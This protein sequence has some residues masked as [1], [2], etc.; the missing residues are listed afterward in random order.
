MTASA[1]LSSAGGVRTRP[2][3][4]EGTGG[5]GEGQESSTSVPRVRRASVTESDDYTRSVAGVNIEVIRTGQ[6]VAPTQVQAA[7][8]PRWAGSSL[9]IGF[10]VF[11]R[12]TLDSDRLGIAVIEEAPKGMRWCG[13][14]MSAGD[15]MVYAPEAN[16]IACHP[17]GARFSFAVLSTADLS[18]VAHRL[19]SSIALRK[20]SV[21]RM[22]PTVEVGLV[23]ALLPN[24]V[25]G[26]DSLSFLNPQRE[27]LTELVAAMLATHQSDD[28]SR[29]RKLDNHKIVNAS[30][31]YAERVDRIPAIDEMCTASHVSERRL[32]TAF[33]ET[34]GVPPHQFFM[35]WAL[36]LAR[37]RLLAADPNR[38]S[39]SWVAVGTGFNHLGRF[40]RYYRKAYGESPSETIR[41]DPT[42]L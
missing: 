21:E 42:A 36:D 7:L 33:V 20:G 3:R 11:S 29:S 9:S 40:A 31:E 28:G 41:R 39:V 34:H 1:D 10:P 22:D 14:D 38:V 37:R 19:Q 18:A 5:S 15:V 16:H 35:K 8:T 24:R 12:T 30:I 6:G 25:R 23:R 13:I 4:P 27:G 17:E 32:H 2:T 26:E